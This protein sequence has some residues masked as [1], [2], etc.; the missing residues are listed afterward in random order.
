MRF[1]FLDLSLSLDYIFIFI[2]CIINIFACYL[3]PAQS[4]RSYPSGDAYTGEWENGERIDGMGEMT[5]TN[6]GICYHYSES[7]CIYSHIEYTYI[8]I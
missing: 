7:I 5:Y 2:Y 4:K 3:Y 8:F 6:G 1:L